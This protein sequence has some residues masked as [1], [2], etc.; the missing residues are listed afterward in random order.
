MDWFL[1]DHGLCHE[2]VNTQFH[3]SKR[4]I[5]VY[6]FLLV[7]AEGIALL[8]HKAICQISLFI[9]N[10]RPWATLSIVFF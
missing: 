9:Y 2:R 8:R 3:N 1:Y 7:V 5:E 6:T 10:S 4:I